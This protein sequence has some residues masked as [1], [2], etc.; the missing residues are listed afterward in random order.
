MFVYG[1]I[2]PLYYQTSDIEER[3][4]EKSRYQLARRF[5]IELMRRQEIWHTL[6]SKIWN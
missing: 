6:K 2:T 3:R 4:R 5:I 1:K